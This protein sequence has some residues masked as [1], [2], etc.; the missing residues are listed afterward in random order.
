MKERGFILILAI[1]LLLRAIGAAGSLWLD[2]IWSLNIALGLP[3]SAAPSFGAMLRQSLAENCHPL[4]AI[5]MFCVGDTAHAW[6]Y[7]LPALLFS[8]AS[9][10]LA[11]RIGEELEGP[12]SRWVYALFFGGSFFLIEYGTEARGYSGVIFHC[13]AGFAIL[14]R[15]LTR[16]KLP[17]YWNGIFGLNAVL[18][19]LSHPIFLG[20]LLGA[21][22]WS[23][24]RIAIETRFRDRV[25][26]RD[27]LERFALPVVVCLGLA[28]SRLEL[29]TQA[30][31]VESSFGAAA[32]DLLHYGFGAPRWSSALFATAALLVVLV[33]RAFQVAESDDERSSLRLLSFLVVAPFLLLAASSSSALSARFL[34][35]SVPFLYILA[36]RGVLRAPDS[37]Q[38]VRVPAP[39]LIGAFLVGHATLLL[40][41]LQYGRG[42]YLEA[43]EQIAQSDQSPL[44]RV[45]VDHPFRSGTVIDY[46]GARL[47]PPR[48]FDK[49]RLKLVSASNRPDWVLLH[50]VEDDDW[51]P[52]SALERPGLRYELRSTFPK[53]G[54]S[55]FHWYLYQRTRAASE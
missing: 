18:G 38:A 36:L 50:H 31:G 1:A 44:I 21:G 46:Y 16:R 19:L 51:A 13:L 9:L 55:G 37:P 5:W 53:F 34:S 4:T 42:H 47:E 22:G 30:S 23:L 25:F 45:G 35:P 24:F 17:R 6:L 41:F 27:S 54:P 52:Q 39:F 43:L 10:W 49:V 40:P 8:V 15:D 20:F 32:A 26:L 28:F 7:R 12:R 2:E 29:Q 33:V 14:Q 48:Q 11:V 3:S